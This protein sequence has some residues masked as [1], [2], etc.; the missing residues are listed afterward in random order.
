[1]I[2]TMDGR[3]RMSPHPSWLQWWKALAVAVCFG[4]YDWCD[5]ERHWA[6]LAFVG[7][8]AFIGG[9]VHLVQLI[10]DMLWLCTSISKWVVPAKNQRSTNCRHPLIVD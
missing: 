7:S 2:N 1:M 3:L 6:S 4:W 10:V 9:Y 5:S 8:A